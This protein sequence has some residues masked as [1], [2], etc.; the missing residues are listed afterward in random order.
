MVH[1]PARLAEAIRGVWPDA[2]ILVTT[3]APQDYLLSS[4][5]NNS[6]SRHEEPAHFA[7]RFGRAAYEPKP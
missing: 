7:A 3:R 6:M 2:H 4:F 1:E 5:N